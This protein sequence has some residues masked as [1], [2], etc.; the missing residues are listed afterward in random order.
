[1]DSEFYSQMQMQGIKVEQQETLVCSKCNNVN[2]DLKSE[3]KEPSAYAEIKP[4]VI[5]TKERPNSSF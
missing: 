1:M 4:P 3:T 2:L 5:K